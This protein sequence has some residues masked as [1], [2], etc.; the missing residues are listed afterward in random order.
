MNNVDAQLSN[1]KGNKVLFDLKE[2]D[3][4]F[5]K[6]KSLKYKLILRRD[7]KINRWMT[8]YTS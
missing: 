3:E 7:Y 4:L 1:L 8:L 5:Q 2:C 6:D